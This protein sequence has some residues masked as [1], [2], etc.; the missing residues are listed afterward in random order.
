M[1]RLTKARN[2]CNQMS[3]KKPT[4]MLTNNDK[5]TMASHEANICTRKIFIFAYYFVE[6]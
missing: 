2:H 3:E 1:Q 6:K 5:D 4:M